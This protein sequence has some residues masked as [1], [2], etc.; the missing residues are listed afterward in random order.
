MDECLNELKIAFEGTTKEK[1]RMAAFYIARQK[2]KILA[3]HW[4]LTS[5]LLSAGNL[6]AL[7]LNQPRFKPSESEKIVIFYNLLLRGKGKHHTHRT[8]RLDIKTS[9]NS[10]G[11]L[12]WV[13]FADLKKD[14]ALE[15]IRKALSHEDIFVCAGAIRALGL[16][17]GAEEDVAELRKKLPHENPHI[18]SKAILALAH[19]GNEDDIMTIRNFHND[20]RPEVLEALV[21]TLSFSKFSKYRKSE[22]KQIINNLS[23]HNNPNVKRASAEALK[24]FEGLKLPENYFER[25]ISYILTKFKINNSDSDENRIKARRLLLSPNFYYW[26]AGIRW[27]ILRGLRDEIEKIIERDGWKLRFAKL[28][29]FD[30]YLYCPQRWRNAME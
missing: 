29:D 20:D 18:A 15:L 1:E 27:F 10:P 6:R 19:I 12:G 26:N 23:E 24:R 7:Y 16:F 8:K 13:W 30:Y 25:S 21:E 3:R 9:M 28:E 2:I 14:K 17:G 11:P 5:E 22:D 4:T